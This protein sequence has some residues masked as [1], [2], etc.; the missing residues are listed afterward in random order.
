MTAVPLG[1]GAYRRNY[2]GAPEIVLLNRWLEQNPANLREGSSV[3]GRPGTDQILTLD[4]G[5]YTGYGSA[6]GNY[7]LS[8][9]F[10]DS[11]FTVVG[12]TL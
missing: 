11:L 9:L 12:N 3:L 10:S 7:A 6:R 2:S 5:G 1:Q 8:G 4:P